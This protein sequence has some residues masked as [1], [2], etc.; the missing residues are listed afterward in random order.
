[1]RRVV[2]CDGVDLTAEIE[3]KRLQGVLFLNINSYAGGTNPWGA[4]QAAGEHKQSFSDKWIEV[5]GIT[6]V[7]QLVRPVTG[8]AN[9]SMGAFVSHVLTWHCIALHCR[10]GSRSASAGVCGYASARRRGS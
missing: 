5:V 6:N 9:R 1:M 8:A 4:R 2:Q 7:A 10:R 3:S